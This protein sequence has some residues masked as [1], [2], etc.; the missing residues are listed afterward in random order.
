L[1][2]LSG[3]SRFDAS[4]GAVVGAVS[5]LATVVGGCDSKLGVDSSLATVVGAIK[6][7]GLLD[8]VCVKCGSTR[9]LAT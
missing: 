7:N 2:P 8:T 3:A 6:G 4:G 9:R 5:S 1:F